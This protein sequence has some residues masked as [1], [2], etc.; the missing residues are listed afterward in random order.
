MR[1]HHGFGRFPLVRYGLLYGLVMAVGACLRWTWRFWTGA[2][3]DGQARTDAT[4]IR[5]GTQLVS[6]L[7]AG[8]WAHRP[9]LA[10]AGIRAGATAACVGLLTAY[11]THPAATARTGLMV[12]VTAA[13]W[14]L[15]RARQAWQGRHFSR[16]YTRPLFGVLRPI[17]GIPVWAKSSDWLT[18]SPDMAGLAPRL[19]RPMSPTEQKIRE[20][21]GERVEP[22]LRWFPDRVMR[23]WWWCLLMVQPAAALIRRPKETDVRPR[24][25][26][27]V[28]DRLVTAELQKQVR[29]AVTAKLGLFDLEEKWNQVGPVSVGKWTIR[30]RPPAAAGIADLLDIFSTLAEPEFFAGLASGEKPVIVSLDDDSPHIACSAGS[31]AGKSVL[32]MLFGV[33]NLA[34]GGRVYILDLK[35]SHRWARGMSGVIYCT[36]A[37]DM[38]R[39]LIEVGQIAQS[40]NDQ[41]MLEDDDW[42]PGARILVIFEE[43]NATMAKLTS[44]WAE[45]REKEDPKTSPAVQAF[46]DLMCMGRSA[47]VNLFGVAQMLTARTT[48]GSEARENFGIRCLARYTANNWKML[49]PEVPMPR[50]SRTRGR[51]QFVVAGEATETQVAFLTRDEAME[52]AST[53]EP[54]TVTDSPDVVLDLR[55]STVTGDSVTEPA[56]PKL[57]TLAEAAREQIVPFTYDSLR[58]IKSREKATFPQGRMVGKRQMWTAEEL[59]SWVQDRLAAAITEER[60]EK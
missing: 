20:F 42:D 50:K 12:A 47:K 54:L 4:W 51:W 48:G 32:A 56:G 40:R 17:L 8:R 33:Q 25:E 19:V 28:A 49:V 60:G 35:G 45:V 18:I 26:L 29:E 23:T 13:L 21:Y 30:E 55:G 57:Y 24:V 27:R 11:N 9:R 37:S 53:R 15:W 39:A 52:F 41:A 38:H 6:K 31:G 1:R 58:Q 2:H 14:G 7:P 36:K 22:V 44:Y 43:M 5:P 3:L 10:R 16:M 34:R 59:E 46:R